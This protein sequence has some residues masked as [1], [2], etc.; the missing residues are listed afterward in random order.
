MKIEKLGYSSSPWR[1]IKDCGEQIFIPSLFLH[2]DLGAIEM[3]EPVCGQTKS[4]CIEKVLN[5]LSCVY[6]NNINFMEPFKIWY[7]LY[8]GSSADGRGSGEFLERT[9]SLEKA[10]AHAVK[11]QKDPYS[12]GSVWLI[13]DYGTMKVVNEKNLLRE[14]DNIKYKYRNDK[15]INENKKAI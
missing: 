6:E 15:E 4:E 14:V 8:G 5:V 13:S 1:L 9:L 10:K 11:I 12:M 2:P 3:S 7:L